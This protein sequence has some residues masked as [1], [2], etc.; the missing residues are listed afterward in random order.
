[1]DNPMKAWPM[2]SMLDTVSRSNVR[3]GKPLASAATAVAP[4]TWR[5][6]PKFTPPALWPPIAVIAMCLILIVATK[7]KALAQ[8]EQSNLHQRWSTGALLGA[9]VTVW[10][11]SGTFLF[12][13]AFF[14]MAFLAQSEYY[15]MAREKGFFP[16][17]KLGTLGAICIYI[18]ACI[19]A[20]WRDRVFPITTLVI[21][22]YLM[23]REWLG[24]IED[25]SKLRKRSASD[26][27]VDVSL[28][29]LGIVTFGYMPSFWMNLHMLG[30][31]K[32][33]A[34]L[35]QVLNPGLCQIMPRLV[36]FNIGGQI[37]WWTC[38]STVS[39]DVAAYFAGKRFGRKIFKEP[40]INISPNKTVEGFLS[41]CL[42][43]ILASSIGATLMGWPWPILSGALY[44][45][46]NAVIAVVGDLLI[47]LVKRWSGVEDTGTALEGH[48]GLLDRI[49]SYLLQAPFDYFYVKWLLAL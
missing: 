15:K 20:E 30:S 7:I 34:V 28:S 19:G 44:G 24:I 5:S 21:I 37:F 17:R 23:L 22:I 6:I 16:T 42:G 48:G 35:E 36:A 33:P 8:S 18:A 12:V 32:L 46:M 25:K 47:S 13:L 10:C 43:S 9:I 49:D 2:V 29:L 14:G 40:L 4:M 3:S 39:A 38:F 1:M 26:V 31:S 11:L 45:F 41:G 27:F